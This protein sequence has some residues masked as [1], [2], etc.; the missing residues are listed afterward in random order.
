M[1]KQ[2]QLLMVTYSFSD[3]GKVKIL[4]P[5]HH[6]CHNARLCFE[7]ESDFTAEVSAR[8]DLVM[9]LKDLFL[10]KHK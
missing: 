5:S 3:H 6:N 8:R 9:S 4:N 7:Y 10:L 2:K 1:Y